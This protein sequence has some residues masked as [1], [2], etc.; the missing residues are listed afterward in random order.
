MTGP[1]PTAPKPR[2]RTIPV[3]GRCG[4]QRVL[5]QG[6]CDPCTAAEEREKEARRG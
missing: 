2:P 6:Y 4:K 1:R 5:F 3:C